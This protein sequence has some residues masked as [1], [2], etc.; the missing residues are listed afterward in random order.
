MASDIQKAATHKDVYELERL[1]YVYEGDSAKLREIGTAL[2]EIVPQLDPNKNTDE[3][4]Y[5]TKAL[6]CPELHAARTA[7]R[8]A[9]GW[10]PEEKTGGGIHA[11]GKVMDAASLRSLRLRGVLRIL[12][13]LGSFIA[14]VGFGLVGDAASESEWGIAI[15]GVG[16]A[17]FGFLLLWLGA[18][19]HR[20][21]AL[22]EGA[23]RSQDL[24]DVRSRMY[25]EVSQG[26]FFA[27]GHDWDHGSDGD[28]DGDGD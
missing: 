26:D 3:L 25:E 24:F 20:R 23:G 9:L 14:L 6:D 7:A 16:L 12:G 4:A 11:T 15:V 22:H 5:I 8:T 1:T 19:A 21:I 18:K 2:Q 13:G 10:P 17:V 28:G 27:G